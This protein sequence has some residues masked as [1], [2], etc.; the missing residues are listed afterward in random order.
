VEPKVGACKQE[1]IMNGRALL[2]DTVY[3][4]FLVILG[5]SVFISTA[6]AQPDWFRIKH[7]YFMAPFGG[8]TIGESGWW[9][10]N[11]WSVPPVVNPGDAVY[12][13]L[14]WQTATVPGSPVWYTNFFGDWAPDVEL[15]RGELYGGIA[16]S[17]MT[18]VDTVTF[19]AP[20]QAGMYRIRWCTASAFAPIDNFYGHPENPVE[21]PGWGPYSEMIFYVVD[22]TYTSVQPPEESGPVPRLSQTYPDPF[23]EYTRID[24]GLPEAGPVSVKVFDMSG[25]VVRTLLSEV[26]D[27]GRYTVTWDGKNDSGEKVASGVFFYQVD[28]PG[29][30]SARKTVL[31][32]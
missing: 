10:V 27:P 1:E 9:W 20:A 21:H 13:E 16:Q 5:M 15:G 25:H 4:T 19:V 8:Q 12:V 30:K 23:S 11:Y 2:R 22:H 31:I 29:L 28:A 17:S 32:K 14:E 26:K 3:C 6:M 7:A 24:F 18:Y